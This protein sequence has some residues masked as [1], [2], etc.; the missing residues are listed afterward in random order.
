MPETN[1]LKGE[2]PAYLDNASGGGVSDLACRRATNAVVNGRAATRS[3]A[4]QRASSDRVLVVV[5]GVE[6]VPCNFEIDMLCDAEILTNTHVPV[7]DSR[8]P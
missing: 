2:L 6:E 3:T 7:V 1:Q 4:D 5:P 8:L